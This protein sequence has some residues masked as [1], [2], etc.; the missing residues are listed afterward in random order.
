MHSFSQP[1]CTFVG[2]IA[3]ALLFVYYEIKRF[4][5]FGHAAVVVLHVDF[6]RLEHAS[7]HTRLGEE[8]DEGTI[9]RQCLVRTIE[10]E[11]THF[12]IF[13]VVALE[14]T[15]CFCEIFSSQLLLYS[16]QTLYKG[17]VFFVHLVFT[18]L[19]WT[20]DDEWRTRIV[21]EHGVYLVDNRIIVL[22]LYEI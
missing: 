1:S 21:D 2:E 11:I 6:F 17:L 15:L 8:L 10:G 18:T 9:L 14:Q 20:R 3:R 4:N 19:H 16:H 22:T 7:F 13:F 12:A 5:R